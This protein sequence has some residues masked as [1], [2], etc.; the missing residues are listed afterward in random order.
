MSSV[1]DSQTSSGPSEPDPSGIGGWLILPIIGFIGTILLTGV[2][3]L[4]ALGE[5]DGLGAIFKATSGPLVALKVPTALSLLAGCLVILSAG[6]C[7]Y[8]VFTKNR[9]IVNIAT[10]HYLILASGGLIDLW[11]SNV[12][13]TTLPM[14]ASDRAHIVTE[15]V[16]D[17]IIACIWIS[18]FRLSR[19]VK[20]TFMNTRG[21]ASKI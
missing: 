15:A 11:L 21:S 6:Y 5:I 9:A 7:L 14:A 16:R 19:R 18:Y 2:N 13:E 3:L 10:A 17:V 1:A 8:L 20:N 12:L 4:Q